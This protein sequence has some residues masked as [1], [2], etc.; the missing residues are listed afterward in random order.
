MKALSVVVDPT[1]YR[2][3]GLGHVDPFDGLL[4]D[5][6]S[7]GPRGSACLSEQTSVLN[8]LCAAIP[9]RERVITCEEVFERQRKVLNRQR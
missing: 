8:C 9:A 6:G 4:H 1:A 2:F 3:V 5:C 7:C